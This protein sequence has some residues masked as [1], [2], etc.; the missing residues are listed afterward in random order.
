MVSVVNSFLIYLLATK[1]P[2]H[3]NYVPRLF[4][5]ITNGEYKRPH[6]VSPEA[7]DLLEKLLIVD[8]M[9]R[10]TIEKIK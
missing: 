3:D 7:L 10:I 6:H 4:K 9:Q 5:K 2:F 8:P 1:L